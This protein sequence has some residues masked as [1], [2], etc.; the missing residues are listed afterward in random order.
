MLASFAL[1]LPVSAQQNV[2]PVEGLRQN[3]PSFHV[4]VGGEVVSPEGVIKATVVIRD[5]RITAIGENVEVP[6]GARVW[7]VAGKRIYPGFIEPWWEVA[8]EDDQKGQHWHK[9]VRPERMVAAGSL[10]SG[11][12]LEKRR[13]LGFCAAHVVAK[14]GIFRGQGA[15]VL[16]RE[17]KRGEQVIVPSTGQVID[18]AN[19][20]GGYPSSLMGA[21]A[22][23]RQTCSDSLW[24]QG[25]SAAH[26]AKPDRIARPA[27][28]RA[29]AALD[30]KGRS[31]LIARDELDYARI[32]ALAGEF[33][34]RTVLRGNGHEYRRLTDLTRLK[35]PLILPMNFPG[36]PS[37]GDVTSGM[38]YSLA[39]LEHW[40]FAPSNPAFLAKE[41]V[42]FSLTAHS[43]EDIG[44][45]FWKQVRLA[46]KRGLPAGDALR[47][48]TSRPARMLGIEGRCGELSP[49]R[50]A[51][52]VVASG[53]LFTDEDAEVLST[54]V[55]G[56]PYPM[57]QEDTPDASGNWEITWPDLEKP[58]KWQIGEGKK[59]KVT[60]G[61]D[62]FDARWKGERLLLFP[63]AGLIGGDEHFARL[64]ASFDPEKKT[65]SGIAVMPGG[66]AFWWEGKRTGD[67]EDKDD[68]GKG[69]DK[70]KGAEK[71]EDEVP[72]LEF[73]HYPAGAYGFAGMPEQPARLLVRGAT[74]WTC[75]PEG[76][77]KDADVLI[78][79]GRV[80]A[81]AK[82]L[83]VPDGAIIIDAA[84]RHVTPGLID[85]HSHAAISRGV[86]EG[87]HSV[88]VEV[89]IGDVVDPTDISLYRQLGGGLTTANLLHGS[90]N[91]MGGQNQVIKLRWGSGAEGMRFKGAKPG[92]KF[93]LG[94]NVKQSNWGPGNTTR[95]PQT[96]MGVEQIMKD[97]FIA[98]RE[99][100]AER[101]RARQE[102]RPH[103]RDLR[104][105]A[106]LEIL[107]GERIVHIH[108]YR[109]DE[110]LMFVR[111]AQEFGFTVGTFQHVLEGYKVADAMAE[112]G[113]G[114]STFSDWWA[115]KFEVYDA[116]AYNG[117]LMHEAGVV[118]SF[119]SDNSELACRMNTEAAKA[120]KYGGVSEEEALKFVTIN[121]AK[122][123]RI[124]KRV[125]SLEP[126]K[127][128]DFVIWSGHPLSTY[129]RAEQTW[130]DGRRY[131]DLESDARLRGEVAE[132][133]GRLIN[134][135]MKK[136]TG[137]PEKS[138]EPGEEKDK[139]D[140]SRRLA[141]YRSLLLPWVPV[142]NCTTINRG[143][144]HDGT[145]LHTCTSG[146][147]K[148]R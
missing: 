111:L 11:E 38:G 12:L 16:L 85:C 128:A 95:Y 132:R 35:V 143:L 68:K 113:A 48:L 109:Q 135:A 99:Y 66:K 42:E 72:P 125:G 60:S 18:F 142:N 116:I 124:D 117:A 93:A 74:V 106:A 20:G 139:E 138:G 39:E 81:V 41:G 100:R 140:P 108:S 54:W 9:G 76:V 91:A 133:R 78:E 61:E 52:L 2:H 86:N 43:L 77:L 79:K 96:R 14:G 7:D 23:V 84:G 110:I 104:L 40:E 115:Y 32:A 33:N 55:D 90:A 49:G 45:M 59:P 98:A 92:V 64:S 120:V 134:R 130:I 27:D 87:T 141:G 136:F 28:D 46:V 73:E 126:G 1:L 25:A 127:D 50:I 8:Q 62:S 34:L 82:S 13:Q 19:G 31:F 30:L 131:F 88:T 112:I 89:R 56:L 69:E 80:S 47:A 101:E 51:N 118:T 114:G 121:P 15:V 119:N 145:S 144:Y 53:D 6:G 97:T 22:L 63:P 146:C 36:D 147:C 26:L 137:K 105:E 75:G 83:K 5:G 148:N 129:S 3:D 71:A 67:L 70:E 24:Y 94:E 122:Q 123:L 44:S 29:L 17:G 57:E 102:G 65:L 4:L 103:R 10:P 37:I 21:I 107:E 58:L